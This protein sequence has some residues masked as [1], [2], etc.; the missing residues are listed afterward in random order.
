M[1]H[2]TDFLKENK[3]VFNSNTVCYFENYIGFQYY[4]VSNLN[5]LA[6]RFLK[7]VVKCHLDLEVFKPKQKKLHNS[8]LRF[9]LNDFYVDDKNFNTKYS[10][11]MIQCSKL[12]RLNN[13]N[14]KY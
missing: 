9:W 14:F 1:L 12:S 4:A 2:I 3:L 11:T 6:F 13:T 8:Q 5:N 7:K 10:S